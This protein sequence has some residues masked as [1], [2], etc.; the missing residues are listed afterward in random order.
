[1]SNTLIHRINT[2]SK[3]NN[4]ALSDHNG[5]ME[6][7]PVFGDYVA[8]TPAEVSELIEYCAKWLAS[9]YEDE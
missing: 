6:L 4:L 2:E 9:G 5:K 7:V 3:E 1:M 8:L